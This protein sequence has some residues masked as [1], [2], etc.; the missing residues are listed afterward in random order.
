MKRLYALPMLLLLIYLAGCAVKQPGATAGKGGVTALVNPF[1]GTGGHGHTYPGAT[2]P[3]GMV[4]LSPDNGTQGWDWCSGYHYSDSLIAGFSHTHLSGT[5]IGDYCDISVMPYYAS[6][7]GR[8]ERQ[9]FS[10]QQETATVGLYRV[11]L[12][13]QIEVALTATERAGLH[14][15]TFPRDSV[16]AVSLDLGFSINWDRPS[17]TRITQVNDTLITGL[18]KSTGWAN[19]QWV[20]FAAAFSQPVQKAV[21]YQEGSAVAGKEVNGTR[22]RA[23]FWFAPGEKPLLLKVALSSASEAGALQNL[24]QELPSWDFNAV[25]Q[26]A[27]TKWERELQKITATFLQPGQDTIFYSALY[28]TNLAPTLFSDLKGQYKGGK[29]QVRTAN[30][31]RYTV[32]SLW[33]TFRAAHPLYTITQPQR[34]P[35]MVRSLLAGYQEMGLLPVWELAANETNTMTGYHAVPVLADALLKGHV[36][37]ENQ[38]TLYQAMLASA[39]QNIRSTDVYRTYGFIPAD[40]GGQSVTK[41]LEYAYDDWC[42]AQVAQK[43][44]KVKDYQAFSQRAAAYQN[45]FD[46]QTLFMRGKNADGSWK[47]PFD[48]FYSEHGEEG[49]YIEGTAW[50]HSWFVPHDVQGLVNLFGSEARF[51]QHLDSTFK[52]SSKMT[53]ANVSP[54]I[55][56]LIGQYA[57]GNEPSHH[58]AYLYN[59]AGKPWKTQE[60]VREILQ[61]MYFNHPDGLSGN[62]DCGQMSAWYVFSALGFYPVNPADGK[63]V[64]GSPLVKEARIQVGQGKTFQIT[65]ENNSLEHKYVQQVF[66]NRQPLRRTYITHQEVMQGGQLKFVMGPS[67][68]KTWGASPAAYPPSMSPKK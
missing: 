43:L 52:V 59:Y 62:E 23:A 64:L 46:P 32:F 6:A 4:Q 16:K 40:K 17:Q 29:D 57:H 26:A 54:D 11:K 50:Q 66:L 61:K 35:D 37:Q 30:F 18:R 14:Q 28:H 20:Y 42:I 12:D 51:V 68:N 8:K 7:V 15:Y 1:I 65:T 58:I 33:D 2:V 24:Q 56:G 45:L 5:G 38:E 55:S 53:G 25:A 63:Y 41:T 31:N 19:Q 3:F 48:P 36:P 10:H 13:N 39:A 22:T 67:P 47:T 44:G 60:K 34:V 49:M 21:L 27:N 9:K